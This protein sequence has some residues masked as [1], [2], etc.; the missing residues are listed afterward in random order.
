MNAVDGFIKVPADGDPL[1]LFKVFKQ[2]FVR[3]SVRDYYS[4]YIGDDDQV[5]PNPLIMLCSSSLMRV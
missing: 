4:S 2:P 1:Q 5:A 3:G